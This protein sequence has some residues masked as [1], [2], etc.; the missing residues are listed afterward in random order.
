MRRAEAA[1]RAIPVSVTSAAEGVAEAVID[2]AGL[3][4]GT[5]RIAWVDVDQVVTADRRIELQLWP[6][7]TLELTRLGR[8]HDT[9]LRE[10]VMARNRARVAG[11]LAHGIAPPALF[12]GRWQTDVS[13]QAVEIQLYATHLTLVP[14][15]GDPVQWP[16]GSVATVRTSDATATVELLG[17]NPP[18][19]LG[20]LG[21][22]RDAF[23]RAV[24]AARDRQ[25]QVLM[26][27]TMRDGFADGCG[28]PSRSLTGFDQL[29]ERSSSPERLEGA[30]QLLALA[31]G[32]DARIGYVQL[33]D[34]DADGLQARSP[35]PE[36]WASFLLVPVGVLVVLELLAGPN[37]ATY[38]FEGE[39]EAVN[40]DLQQLHFRRAQLALSD[41][42]AEITLDNPHRLALR[43]LEPLRR[44]RA[45]TRA[46]I[47][48][49]VAW[50]AAVRAA[51]GPS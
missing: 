4:V 44:L 38:V 8:R 24:A 22:Q 2:D 40:R 28:M 32:G 29:L 17:R 37:A 31:G 3:G 14:E 30:R 5:Q 26:G 27:Y 16:L 48:H 25:A 18:V 1:W 21:R 15:V 11:L 10:L 42:Q 50:S 49:A 41:A 20:Q 13:A 12:T 35:L 39:I 7:G 33:L 43:R 23:V 9:F 34:P 6:T 47:V 36:G 51:V 46:R 45:A 19:C